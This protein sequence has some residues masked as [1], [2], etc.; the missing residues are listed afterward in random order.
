MSLADAWDWLS[1]GGQN[2][3]KEAKKM[4]K[5]KLAFIA[6]LPLV[7]LLTKKEDVE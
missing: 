3:Y 7:Y 4:N 2:I 5:W 1:K 6:T